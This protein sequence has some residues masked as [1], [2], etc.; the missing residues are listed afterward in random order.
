MNEWRGVRRRQQR[1][2]QNIQMKFKLN[3]AKR[4]LQM[5]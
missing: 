4:S 2:Q 1:Q 5:E 3:Y